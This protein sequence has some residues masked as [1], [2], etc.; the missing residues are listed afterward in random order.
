MECIYYPELNENSREIEISGAEAKH[1]SALRLQTNDVIMLSNGNGLC[2][3]SLIINKVKSSYILKPEK[4]LPNHGE[5]SFRLGFAIGILNDRNRLEFALE[6]AVELGATDFFPAITEFTEKRRINLSRLSKKAVAAMKQC[7]RANLIN[8]HKPVKFKKIDN[9]I[10]EFEN[11]ILADVEGKSPEKTAELKSTLIFIGPEGGF[12]DKEI[13][14]LKS[15]EN[16]IFW[17]LGERRLR[18]E[19]AAVTALSMASM[20]MKKIRIKL[21]VYEYLSN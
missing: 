14:T 18:A 20:K 13:T 7:K 15:R 1:I 8:I 19:T 2:A 4:F 3:E 10:Q 11:V 5:L 17:K 6:K 9:F 16:I 21:P 12:S